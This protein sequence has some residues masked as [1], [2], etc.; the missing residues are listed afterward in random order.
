MTFVLYFAM[1]GVF[2]FLTLNLQQIQQFSATQAGAAFM[3]IIILL[4]L[5]SLWSGRYADKFG[6]RILLIVGPAVIAIGF[7]L[8]MMPGAEANYWLTFFPA[9]VVFGIGL[10]IT[11]APLTT[12]AL[13]AV[14]THLSG[15][16]SGVSNA[17]ARI[18]SML[19][20]ALLGF[21]M[22]LQFGASLE[23]QLAGLSLP[24]FHRDYWEEEK[25]KLGGAEPPPGLSAPLTEQVQ[26]AIDQAFVDAFRV[27]M[28]LCGG[29]ALVSAGISAA[30]ISNQLIHHDDEPHPPIF[31]IM[32]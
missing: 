14:P 24:V 10:G 6:P 8:Y 22:V 11:V 20:V 19:A 27:M 15:L 9:T 5:M 17:A 31:E 21:V 18:A 2:Y 3:P 26:S 30:T 32:G 1:S 28:G 12:V 4:F 7:F 16:A 29:L 25:L 13:G 23:Q